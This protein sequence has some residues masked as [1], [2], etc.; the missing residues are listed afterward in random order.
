MPGG[1]GVNLSQE[2]LNKIEEVMCLINFEL[3]TGKKAHIEIGP[4]FYEPEDFVTK[5]RVFINGVQVGIVT[6]EIDPFV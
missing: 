1:A 6:E 2:T 4:A 5:R 3:K